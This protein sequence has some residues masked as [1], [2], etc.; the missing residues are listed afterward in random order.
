MGQVTQKKD[1]HFTVIVDHA[2]VGCTNGMAILVYAQ[3]EDGD[4]VPEDYLN[5]WQ[6]DYMPTNFSRIVFAV[7]TNEYRGTGRLFWNYPEIPILPRYVLPQNTLRYQN[8]SW[9]YVERDDGL[10]TT[11][12]TNVLQAVRLERNWTNYFHLARDGAFSASNRI[13]EDSFHDM[14]GIAYYATHPQRAFL[15]ADPLVDEKHKALLNNPNWGRPLL[16][17]P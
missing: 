6:N 3:A 16:E 1:D 13:K 10:L 17:E 15:L 2:L 8:R 11:Q 5:T 9:W 12:F 7:H 4:F 14:R